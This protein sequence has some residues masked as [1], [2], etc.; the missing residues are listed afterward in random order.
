MKVRL[1]L[2]IAFLIC[3]N[4]YATTLVSPSSRC[5]LMIRELKSGAPPSYAELFKKAREIFELAIIDQLTLTDLEG[6]RADPLNFSNWSDPIFTQNVG[7]VLKFIRDDLVTQMTP[8]QRTQFLKVNVPKLLQE[9]I[10][11]KMASSLQGD[12]EKNNL[13]HSPTR[14]IGSHSL[15]IT[16]LKISPDGKKLYSGSNDKNIGVWNAKSYQLIKSLSANQQQMGHL[17][18]SPDEKYLFSTASGR[19]IR[20]WN[21]KTFRYINLFDSDN[22]IRAMIASPDG[23][24]IYTGTQG[25]EINQWNLFY[26]PPAH[27][28][29]LNLPK[30]KKKPNRF[31]GHGNTVFGLAI[32]KDSRTLYSGA[33]DENIFIWDTETGQTKFILKGHTGSLGKLIL[34][35]DEQSLYSSSADKTIIIW[36]LKANQPRA[37]L[38]GHEDIIDSLAIAPNQKILYSGSRDGMIGVWDLKR[39]RLIRMIRNVDHRAIFDLVVSKNNR[40]L[41]WA[42][43]FWRSSAGNIFAVD[44]TRLLGPEIVEVQP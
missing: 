3:S 30:Q 17:A 16:A 37:K 22:D 40:T 12:R 34:S 2:L 15:I 33:A 7:G 31:L 11:E 38:E 41:F 18:L 21:L 32:S 43:S 8:H 42:S 5:D 24:R 29:K 23:R 10:E 14:I 25:G 26:S 4:L 6:L 27:G 39:N 1:V 9:K 19:I 36:D 13:R 44:L 28:L 20:R 35:K